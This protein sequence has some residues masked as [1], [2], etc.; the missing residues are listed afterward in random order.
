MHRLIPTGEAARPVAFPE[1]P[2]P[3]PEPGAAFS[4]VEAYDVRAA[5]QGPFDVVPESLTR[6]GRAS[7]TPATPGSFD[8]R[9]RRILGKAVLLTGEAR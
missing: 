5:A 8:L 1:A 2:Q 3:V 9:E 6:F 7:R 4:E